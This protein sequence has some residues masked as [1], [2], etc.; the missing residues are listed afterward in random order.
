M[1]PKPGF[2]KQTL[3]TKIRP[4]NSRWT[5]SQIESLS[6]YYELGDWVVVKELGG[7]NSD[8]VLLKT[9]KG[10]KVLK[11]YYWSLPSTEYEHS[12]IKRI[13]D[14]DPKFP[15]PRIITNNQ[16][17]TITEFA[18]SYYGIYDVIDGFNYS[19][20]FLPPKTIEKFVAQAAA[21]LARFHKLMIDFV[22]EGKKLNCFVPDGTCLWR[23]VEWHLEVIDSYLE[24]SDENENY[25]EKVNFLLTIKDELKQGLVETGRYY[26]DSDQILPKLIIHGDFKP[27]NLLF[28]FQGIK[29]VLD[30]GDSNLNF[31]AADIARGLSTFTMFN[32]KKINK[33]L[34]QIFVK[35]YHEQY[36]LLEVEISAIPD[37]I[38]WRYYKTIVWSLF[39]EIKKSSNLRL[40]AKKNSLDPLQRGW[41]RAQSVKILAEDLKSLLFSSIS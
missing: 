25:D 33:A 7:G 38:L 13:F 40:I 9:Q 34:L 10:K 8:N 39:N 20:Y 14:R 35:C 3:L 24:I 6:N 19:H 11:K 12:I 36:P 31:K 4:R 17:S 32:R 22:P 30:F 23:N 2:V 1:I 37:L 5:F 29:A 18:G 27:D 41:E 26:E 21:T 28:N 15:A 16:G